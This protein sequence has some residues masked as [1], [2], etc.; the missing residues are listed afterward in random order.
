MTR[1]S[2]TVRARRYALARALA[3]TVDDSGRPTRAAEALVELD[4]AL[5]E[6]G[7]DPPTDRINLAA[8]RL[9]EHSD[10][11]RALQ[12]YVEALDGDAAEESAERARA[13][14]KASTQPAALIAALQPDTIQTVARLARSGAVAKPRL[15]VSAIERV[16]RSTLGRQPGQVTMLASTLLRQRGGDDEAL[17]LLQRTYADVGSRAGEVLTELAE[18]LLD[19]NRIDDTVELVETEDDEGR[20]PSLQLVRAEAHLIRGEFRDALRLSERLL[21]EVSA[22]TEVA[23]VRALSLLGL[24]HFDEALESLDGFESLSAAEAPEVHF[25]RTV[26]HLQ[27]REYAAARETSWSLLRAQPNDPDALLL[28]AQTVVEALGAPRDED[29]SSGVSSVDVGALGPGAKIDAAR[30]L[31]SDLVPDLP[32]AGPRSRWW[33]AQAAIRSEDGR[34]RFFQTELRLSL[35]TEV[36]VEELNAVH[37]LDTTWLQ[38]AALEERKGEVLDRTEEHARA[39]EAYD[40]ACRIFRDFAVDVDRASAYART[41]YERMPT[42]ERA[43]EYARRALATS[44]DAT[45][46]A[47][48]VTRL[49]Q[50]RGALERWLSGAEDDQLAPLANLLAWVRLRVG[51]LDIEDPVERASLLLPMLFVGIAV[52]PDDAVLRAVVALQLTELDLKTAALVYATD[53]FDAEPDTEYVVETAVVSSAN[54]WGDLDAAAPLLARHT[55]VNA[56][57]TWRNAVELNLSMA[58]GDRQGVADHHDR[59][60][61]DATWARREHAE[62]TALLRG[63]PDANAELNEALKA[64]LQINPP[65]HLDAVYLAALLRRRDD[66]VRH[67]AAARADPSIKGPSLRTSELVA[68]FSFE[69][70][71]KQ[72]QFLEPAL[73]F[74]RCPAEVRWLVNVTLPLLVSAK[75]GSTGPVLATPV[76]QDLVD[77]RLHEFGNPQTRYFDELDRYRSGLSLLAR[78]AD[79]R[80]GLDS[81]IEAERETDDLWPEEL[82]GSVRERIG[83]M[84]VHRAGAELPRRLLES[85]L[86]RGAEVGRNDVQLVLGGRVDVPVPARLATA[87]L[88]RAAGDAEVKQAEDVLA[89]ATEADITAAADEIVRVETVEDYWTL[90]AVVQSADGDPGLSPPLRGVASATR[91][92]LGLR[93]DQLLGLTRDESALEIPVVIPVVVEIGDGLVPIVDSSQDGGVFLEELIPAMR[94]RIDAGTGVSVPGVRMRGDSMLPPDGYR[95][96]VDE[97]P[98]LLGSLPLGATFAVLPAH[99]GPHPGGELTDVHP[100]TGERGL[101]VLHRLEDGGDD[102]ADHLTTAQYLIHRIELVLRAHLARYLGLQE[103]ALLVATWSA[104]DDE[105]LVASV[106]PDAEA[107][108]RL[109][110]VLQALVDDGVPITDWRTILASIREAGGIGASTLS[111]RRAV[112]AELRDHLPGPEPGRKV[113]SVPRDQQDALLALTSDNSD[114]APPGDPRHEFLRWLRARIGEEGPALTLVTRAHDVRELVSALARIES[115]LITTLSEDEVT[116][117]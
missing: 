31:L 47:E 14:L 71:M 107:R 110:W 9:L 11:A 45:E 30:E 33:H 10:P 116:S 79:I 53:A 17:E 103:V 77:A 32:E 22:Q 2:A 80:T 39:A 1:P 3:E 84:I 62:A 95:I 60:V 86:G 58:A 67:L 59:P 115:P 64:C 102:A 89:D 27:R 97:V 46:P 90:E 56:D 38:K 42:A 13:L 48:E 100:L 72:D 18:T 113:V 29:V 99:G 51:Q 49:D 88:A 16:T 25:A 6:D 68:Q 63:I 114:D 75:L 20:E 41:A 52:R 109:T 26:G 70:N 87:L 69:P 8:G 108:V 54:Y 5:K 93:L 37:E 96:Q 43:A 73:E 28:N 82:P 24:R 81:L 76:D 66:M 78:L 105:E 111:L 34:Y 55:T 104:A 94:E 4:Q 74:C 36:T 44:Y 85:R 57:D 15:M 117:S 98:V 61:T 23:A 91:N 83:R 12:R 65:S 101:W 92:G 112:R 19:R 7:D 35:G 40:E 50:V 106:L 21:E